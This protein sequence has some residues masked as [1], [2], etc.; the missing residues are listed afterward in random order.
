MSTHKQEEEGSHK[1]ADESSEVCL[2]GGRQA[3]AQMRRGAALLVGVESTLTLPRGS[4]R[5]REDKLSMLALAVTAS[6][7]MKRWDVEGELICLRLG[8]FGH[9]RQDKLEGKVK[10]RG[11]KERFQQVPGV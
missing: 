11:H 8:A 5:H 1:L 10:L 4:R 6:G 2:E 7:V 9:Q 3:L